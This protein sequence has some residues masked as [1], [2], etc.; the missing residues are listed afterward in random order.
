MIPAPEGSVPREGHARGPRLP[1]KETEAGEVG[2]GLLLA[3]PGAVQE[4]SGSRSIPLDRPPFLD[5]E[6]AAAGAT[7]SAPRTLLD[8]PSPLHLPGGDGSALA[9]RAGEG[10]R[11]GGC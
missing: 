4:S 11:P 8:L 7:R 6:S 1:L 3:I 9:S 2:E 10:P 5:S